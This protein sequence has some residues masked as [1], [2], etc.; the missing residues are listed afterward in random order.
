M[1]EIIMKAY[2]VAD[3]FTANAKFKEIARLNKLI[4]QLYPNEIK[5]F[6]E[7]KIKYNDVMQYGGSYHPDFKE[8]TKLLSVTKMN[9]YQQKEVD[10]Y[11]KLEREF[12]KEI[13]DYLFELSSLISDHI[14]SPNAFGIVK[15]GGSC[16]VG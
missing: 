12:E 16:H 1:T 11:L 14:P 15:K 8:V 7:A 10:T 4:D 13:N 2:E 9:L 6:D 5:A 3:E